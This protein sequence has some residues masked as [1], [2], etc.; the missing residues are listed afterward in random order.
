MHRSFAERVAGF[1]KRSEKPDLYH[2]LYAQ[3]AAEFILHPAN[4]ESAI[5][6]FAPQNE[7]AYDALYEDMMALERRLEL[8]NNDPLSVKL[9][10]TVKFAVDMNKRLYPTLE[11][12]K[13]AAQGSLSSTALDEMH[14][15]CDALFKPIAEEVCAI[16]KRCY[17]TIGQ[18]LPPH[19]GRVD[20]FTKF[21]VEHIATKAKRYLWKEQ[22]EQSQSGQAD[23]HSR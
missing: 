8:Q 14:A 19:E 5:S 17:D 10:E 21:M 2:V 22:F 7:E 13:A 16:Q 6:S 3:V 12:S 11:D 20:Q 9:M 1:Q 15:H 23:G 4:Q 18:D